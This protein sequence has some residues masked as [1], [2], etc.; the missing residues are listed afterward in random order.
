M[1]FRRGQICIQPEFFEVQG[2][3]DEK[4]DQSLQPEA[5][6]VAEPLL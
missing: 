1:F 5:A 2:F 4:K 3:L 6:E